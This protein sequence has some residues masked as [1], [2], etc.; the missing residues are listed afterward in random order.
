MLVRVMLVRVMLVHV[1]LV[2]VARLVA[3]VTGGAGVL[4]VAPGVCVVAEVARRAR[5]VASA[6]R[7]G[8][9]GLVRVTFVHGRLPASTTHGRATRLLAAAQDRLE[10]LDRRYP[11]APR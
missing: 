10:P 8:R 9:F 7:A 6:G 11:A 1:M 2:R 5:V 3:G 4:R